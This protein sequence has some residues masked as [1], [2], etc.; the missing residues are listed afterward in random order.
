MEVTEI[1]KKF[2]NLETKFAYLEDYVQQLQEVVVEH[3][4][5][6]DKLSAANKLMEERIADFLEN[7]EEIPNRKPPHY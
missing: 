6:I 7:S 1:E 4:K 2:V 5:T 3:T